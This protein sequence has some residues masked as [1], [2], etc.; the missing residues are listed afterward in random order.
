MFVKQH[1]ILG[2]LFALA[3]FLFFPEIGLINTSLIFLSSVLIDVDHYLYY[4]H[5]RKNWSLKKAHKWFV[6]NVEEKLI[7]IPKTQRSRFYGGFF[8][9]H[10]IEFLI[11]SFLLIFLSKYFLFIFTGGTF[12][13]LFDIVEETRY[14]NR[15]DKFS[16]IY[17]WKKFKKLTPI[18]KYGK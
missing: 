6:I 12:H 11:I 15:I 9:L 17:D 13:L 5:K 8:F 1:V 2:G 3:L 7:V 18:E 10:G 14:H 4:V 16:S